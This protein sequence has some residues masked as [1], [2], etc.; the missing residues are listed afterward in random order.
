MNIYSDKADHG[1][2]SAAAVPYAVICIFY[3]PRPQPNFSGGRFITAPT[4]RT[5]YMGSIHPRRLGSV[6]V[7]FSS[8]LEE[9]SR[10]PDAFGTWSLPLFHP[11]TRI[12]LR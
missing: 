9:S 2:A 11:Y 4:Q 3:W 10:N 1:G 6:A 12:A 7:H 8:A 5:R